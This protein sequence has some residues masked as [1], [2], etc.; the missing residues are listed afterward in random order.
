MAVPYLVIGI[1]YQALRPDLLISPHL[2]MR[3]RDTFIEEGAAFFGNFLR[4]HAIYLVVATVGVVWALVR[5]QRGVLPPLVWFLTTFTILLY[6][7]P[8]WYHHV[9]LLNVPLAWLTAFGVEAWLDGWR[10]CAFGRFLGAAG[11]RMPGLAAAGAMVA[12]L[13]AWPR[14]FNERLDEQM[15]IYRPLFVWDI[16]QRL[17][18]EAAVQGGWIFTDRPYY[19]FRANTPV[20]P[21]VAVLSR[22]RMEAGIITDEIMLAGLQEYEPTYVLTE[23]FTGGYGA[24]IMDEI[25]AHYD[26]MAQN[27][28]AVLYK[29]RTE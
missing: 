6:Y 10:K 1:Y 7:R 9:V 23:R 22:K 8:I 28:P 19:A 12:V 17:I 4:L 2:R 25:T 24:M 14:P 3:T 27:N 26:L 11:L 21:T 13:W 15:A 29:R 18:D 5:R 16:Q 20:I